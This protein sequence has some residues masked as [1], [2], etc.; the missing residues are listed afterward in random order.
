MSEIKSKSNIYKE[1]G[2]KKEF[3][4]AVKKGGNAFNIQFRKKALQ[5][6]FQ[7]YGD[8]KY[9]PNSFL[10]YQ[11]EYTTSQF[12]R[13]KTMSKEI[14][15]EETNKIIETLDNYY[16][17]PQ[18]LNELDEEKQ[19]EEAIK[20]KGK[21]LKEIFKKA[22]YKMDSLIEYVG[23]QIVSQVTHESSKTQISYFYYEKVFALIPLLKVNIPEK[24]KFDISFYSYRN[25]LKKSGIKLEDVNP[26]LKPEI[27]EINREELLKQENHLYLS[28]KNRQLKGM[29]N[30]EIQ[31]QSLY[32]LK[33]ADT[34]KRY[35]K[36]P[37]DGFELNGKEIFKLLDDLGDKINK[38]KE[39]I[40]KIYNNLDNQV[41]EIKDINNKDY[42][43]R[44]KV[45]DAIISSP[46]SSY[47]EY[48]IND[49]NNNEII[50]SK[51][52]LKENKSEPYTRIYNKNNTKDDYIYVPKKEIEDN[53]NKLKYI[54]Q[55][56]N[57]KGKN[58][59]NEPKEIK[60]I[61]MDVECDTLP[62]LEESKVLYSIPGEDALYK[63]TKD[64]LLNK[65]NK[66]NKDNKDILICEK[67]NKF[68]P[69]DTIDKIK[70]RDSKVK[71]KNIKYKVKDIINKDEIIVIEY[72]DIFDNEMPGDYILINNKDS[73]NEKILVNKN[74]LVNELNS[75]DNPKNNIKLKNKITNN[76][77]EINPTKI[78]I[79]TPEKE[80]I[81]QNY[82]NLQNEIK[83]KIK[84]ENT[85]I[86]TNNILIKKPIIKKVIDDKE[87]YDIYYIN[88]I[89]NKKNK[90]S[91]K[92]LIKDNED[93]TL[94][95]III[96][97]EDEPDKN[98]IVPTK[99][100]KTKLD[101]DP[102]EEEI[103]INDNEGKKHTIK[104]TKI[105]VK[106]LEIEE[107]NLEE[108]PQKIKKDLLKDIKDY[109]YLY[110]DKENK[111]HYIRGD[112]LNLIKNYKS[113]YPIENFEV[114]DHKGNR[115]DIPKEKAI[116][117]LENKNEPK[118]I[119]L[120]DEE[121]KGEPIIAEYDILEKC[122]N[123]IDEPV[124]VNKDGKKIKLKNIKKTILKDIKTIGEQPEE[125]KFDKINILIKDIQKKEPLSDIIQVKDIK[126]NNIY[127]YE[128]T[129]NKIEENKA[130]PEKTTYKGNNP[131]KEEIIC[132]KSPNKVSP[133]TYLKLTEPNI[134]VDKKELENALKGYKPDKKNIS[135]KDI[136]GNNSEFDPLN[137][138]IYKASP[139]ET[140]IIKILPA[141]FSDINQK[142]LIDIVPH[143][144]YILT[145]DLNN[146]EILI[147]K[148]EGDNLIKYP[149]TDF[150]DYA[151]YDKHGKKIKISRTKI[152]KDN[153]DNK[154]EYIE[155]KDNSNN[156]NEIIPVNE[157]VK[158]LNDKEN[159][160]FEINNKDGKKLKLNKKNIQIIKQDNKYIDIPEQGQE[161]KKRLLSDIKDSFIKVKDSKNNK[162]T[163]LRNSQLNEI[164][165][166]KQK[167]PFI[168]YEIINPKKEK[169]YITKEIC[170]ENISNPNN[171]LILCYD[172][173]QKD[174]TFLVPQINIQNVKCDGDDQFDIGDGN[175]ILFKNLRIKKLE[176][177]P[178][179]GPQP[180][181][182]KMIKVYN[183]INKIKSGPLNK[184][185]KTKN[186]EDN[187]IFVNNNY[188]N[189]LQNESKEDEKDTKYK[190]N[191]VFGKNKIIINKETIDKDNKPGEYII[192]KNTN[193]N[194]NYLVD[195]NDLINNLNN[196]KS[197]DED[198][199]I[200]N[201]LNN[202]NIKINPLNIV[203]VP[204]YNDFPVE[205]I[206]TKKTEENKIEKE[207]KEDEDNKEKEKNDEEDKYI[208]A[209]RMRLRSMPMRLQMPE[210]KTYKIRRAI[211]YKKQRKDSQ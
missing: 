193:N 41:F 194:E 96:I 90:V 68:I 185:Y 4:T 210:K 75:W 175:K 33:G 27:K 108:Q 126:N 140:D 196:F 1:I 53:F 160:E 147:K 203:I 184:N 71:N 86:K 15:E 161:I 188:I 111:P 17:I 171:K 187:V 119:S 135:I 166:Y 19:F 31:D 207:K 131:M 58:K 157:F 199:N 13:L 144:K 66:D 95:Y 2:S 154:Y 122:E 20:M 139:E 70:V 198:I 59:N 142:L 49:V 63:N 16:V 45:L 65:I 55:E 51:K 78:N 18:R 113:N 104:K 127:I 28:A 197:I 69:L 134:I 6:I 60:Y 21:H 38:K 114:E 83:D 117:I 170:Q 181:E 88:D 22:G 206:K 124:Q 85:L 107:I 200:T 77:I 168:N 177:S 110:N 183:L 34:C 76:E 67:N 133:N 130:D 73:P 190:I 191:D 153:N 29:I 94:E 202:E 189:K 195:Y 136:K 143:N 92:Q 176:D 100:I 120:D 9:T 62:L 121:T 208:N 84:P 8:E 48:K 91:K 129:S 56:N 182:E 46:D 72:K 109:Y 81:P 82:E 178:D 43:I 105:K 47:D 5:R 163:L 80:E 132:G 148:R 150:D 149:K 61:L 50:V 123:D 52:I 192:I 155:I 23:F 42:Y 87:D 98:I 165:N 205:K 204:P 138:T 141:D 159:E 101:E 79:L 211:I 12:K 179:M 64:D 3:Y 74:D 93:E 156:T 172:E 14:D 99:E 54:K 24:E 10:S 180:E 151:L 158:A 146:K 118:Y 39:N 162:D 201:A 128:D 30:P 115:I 35:P 186:I 36:V 97:N 44:K 25:I 137:V 152:E 57:F 173:T 112:T 26:Y 145:K 116:Q 103:T 174:K 40:K 169:V 32:I 102:M 167:A 209:T 89:N 125:K 164:I 106:P 37:F 11:I 7:L